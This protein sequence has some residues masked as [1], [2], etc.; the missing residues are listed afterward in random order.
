[1]QKTL[2]ISSKGQIT[3]PKEI[4]EALNSDLV[5]IVAEGETIRLE[6]IKDVGG[7]LKRFASRFV[8]LKKARE[9]AR[10]EAL[11]EKHMRD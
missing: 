6:P 11:R 9:K 10:T 7:S 5:R 2:K 4:R 3:I 8:P 1:M